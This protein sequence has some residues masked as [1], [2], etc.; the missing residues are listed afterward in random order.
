MWKEPDEEFQE[1]KEYTEAQLEAF[2]D[3]ILREDRKDTG[4]QHGILND[5]QVYAHQRR[6]VL[7]ETG[8]PEPEIASGIYWRA[9]PEGRGINSKQSRT[10]KGG[11]HA[12]YK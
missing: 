1:G 7:N 10:T 5:R 9:H 2:A 4:E 6:E 3:Q 11:A 8:T 12:F